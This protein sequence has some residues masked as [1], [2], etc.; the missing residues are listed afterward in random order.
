MQLAKRQAGIKTWQAGCKAGALNH[1]PLPSLQRALPS[2]KSSRLPCL[3][4]AMSRG[5]GAKEDK[6]GG[7]GGTHSPAAG[8]QGGWLDKAEPTPAYD[9]QCAG[10]TQGLVR[11]PRGWY[12][13][14]LSPAHPLQ[15]GC[16]HSHGLP[17]SFPISECFPEHPEALWS[18]PELRFVEGH[19]GCR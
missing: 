15:G 16:Q 9:L 1:F 3:S 19:K 5:Q 4:G 2:L 14:S 6:R 8:G 10:P 12:R 13:A 17:V 7:A 18:F 11:Q